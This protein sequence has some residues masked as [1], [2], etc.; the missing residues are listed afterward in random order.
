MSQR[1]ANEGAALI[2]SAPPP[3]DHKPPC[4]FES[5]RRM[6][7]TARA[8]KDLPFYLEGEALQDELDARLLRSNLLSQHMHDQFQADCLERIV[9]LADGHADRLK[10]AITYVRNGRVGEKPENSPEKEYVKEKGFGYE[11]LQAMNRLLDGECCRENV[12]TAVWAAVDDGAYASA[13]NAAMLAGAG[14]YGVREWARQASQR[15]RAPEARRTE[16]LWQVARY[17]HYLATSQ[18]A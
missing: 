10:A 7:Y 11:V 5:A 12:L 13:S 16:F 14:D 3:L 2:V 8:D 15:T 17:K 9:S 18:S 1:A 4:V 6:R